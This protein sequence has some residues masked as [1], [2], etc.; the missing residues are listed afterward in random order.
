MEVPVHAFSLTTLTLFSA[1]LC[2]NCCDCPPP[3]AGECCEQQFFVERCQ[4]FVS[5]EFLYWTADEG[6]LDYAIKMN[7]P[8]WGP[9]D[10]FAT[11]KYQT[12]AYEFRPGYRLS[13]AWYNEPK[14]WEITGQ[15][16]WLYDKGSDRTNKPSEPDL[17]VNS[18]W[19]T[20]TA[21]PLRKAT[22]LIDLHYHLGDVY[23]ARIFDPNPHLRLRLIGG[24][25]LAHIEQS[26]KVRYSNFLDEHDRIKNKWRYFGGGLRLAT[27]VDWFWFWQ[28]YLTGKVSFATL[29]GT[30]KNQA[31]QRTNVALTPQDNPE[32]NVRDITYDDH[33][34]AFHT[35][36]L[37]GPSFQLPCEC[38]SMEIFAGYEFNIWMNLQEVYRS[39]QSGPSGA[40]ETRLATG[41]FGLHGLTA[42]LTIGF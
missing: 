8:A 23:V 38:W 5:T 24:L 39:T 40:K 26:W 19:N 32:I 21:D 37:V 12:A 6:A 1:H 33:R 27:T 31:I 36:F 17:F 11:G 14:Y 18:T 15:Y 2:A 35:Q 16:T 29:L 7:R 4:T 42:R 28:V 9:S 41:L 22:S 13:L 20:I 30:Y 10:A 3:P 25:T 34:F